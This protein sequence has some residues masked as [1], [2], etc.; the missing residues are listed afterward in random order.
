VQAAKAAVH[1][2]L[3]SPRAAAYG[4]ALYLALWLGYISAI[5]MAQSEIRLPKVTPVE[6]AEAELLARLLWGENANTLTEDEA[7]GI[8]DSVLNRRDSPH[9]PKTIRDV[10]LQP[11][12]YT[13]F[14]P[15][16]PNYERIQR[17]D[18]SHP[19]WQQYMSLA[20]K[21]LDP[22]RKRSATTHYFSQSP[23]QWASSMIGLAKKGA[24]WFGQEDP[25]SRKQP[26]KVAVADAFMVRERE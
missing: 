22:A 3:R 9:Y 17:F 26:L 25:K 18:P 10:I 13:P 15:N 8:G 19:K 16:N 12:Q 14:N 21:I 7:M 6:P 24:H 20:T 2:Y 1:Q 11:N 23:P 5:G 4:S